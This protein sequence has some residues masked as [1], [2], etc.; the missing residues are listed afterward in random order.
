MREGA[1]GLLPRGAPSPFVE[2]A[3]L[4]YDGGCGFC[5]RSVLFVFARDPAGRFRF[6]SLQ[7]AFG[8]RLLGEHGVPLDVDTVVLVDGGRAYVRSTAA[9]RVGR[10]LRWPWSWL[11][12]LGFVVPR[13]L[14][15]AAYRGFAKRRHRLFG[16][17]DH[18]ANPS[19]ELRSRMLDVAPPR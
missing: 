19:P 15:D 8:R 5:T 16:R 6:A 13:P 14:R 3:I 9:L 11:A 7:S 1:K 4:L 2:P 10:G 17:E 12:A 18:C